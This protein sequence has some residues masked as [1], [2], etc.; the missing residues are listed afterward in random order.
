MRQKQPKTSKRPIPKKIWFGRLAG[1]LLLL[2]LPVLMYGQERKQPDF[3]HRNSGSKTVAPQVEITSDTAGALL[4]INNAM[5]PYPGIAIGLSAG[6]Q[7]IWGID[8][9]YQFNR[10]FAIRAGFNYLAHTFEETKVDAGDEEL[11]FNADFDQN[12]IMLL[13]E[14]SPG[15]KGKFRLVAGFGFHLNNT[16]SG[17]GILA[18]SIMIEDIEVSPEEVGFIRGNIQFGSK[19]S[20]YFG[21]GFGRAVPQKRVGIG[22][23][24]GTYYKGRPKVD[25]EATSLLRNN[26]NNEQVLED[27]ISFVRWWPVISFRLA[28]KI[29]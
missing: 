12:N 29:Q 14:Y 10:Q 7:N 26:V 3:F 13:G 5:T 4:D 28:V 27:A 20:P 25:L 9:A 11:L 2:S 15:K 24:L 19:L 23:D 16:I 22:L 17:E 6:T 1:F 18:D 8:A 21:L